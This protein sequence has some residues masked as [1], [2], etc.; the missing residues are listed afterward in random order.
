MNSEIEREC[1]QRLLLATGKADFILESP[2]PP[3]PDVKALWPDGSCDVFEVTEV[4]PDENP[5]YGSAARADEERHL[6][7][8]SQAI[9]GTWI[10]STPIP[11]IGYRIADKI[12]KAQGYIVNANEPLSLL[13]VGGLLKPGAVAA[14]SVVPQF[15]TTEL[16]NQHFHESLANS[17]FDQ[18][19][20]HLQLF[21]AIWVW[22]KIK[23]WRVLQPP[24]LFHEGRSALEMLRSL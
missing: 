24:N 19:Y 7:R 6:R 5:G 2:S 4:H 12:R 11:A 13:L 20:L 14:T 3:A 8:D 15:L 18:A 17:R 10:Q 9:H 23:G 16:L 21:G 22:D 1:V